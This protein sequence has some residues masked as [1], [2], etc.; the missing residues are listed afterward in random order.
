MDTTVES[1]LH[2]PERER[3]SR[4]H[5]KLME[6]AFAADFAAF[7]K[8]PPSAYIPFDIDSLVYR[9]SPRQ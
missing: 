6:A 1:G 7:K 3:L 2:W 5:I 9:P 4:E 8:G